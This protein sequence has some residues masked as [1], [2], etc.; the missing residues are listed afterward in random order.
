MHLACTA[1]YN[2]P[3]LTP[4]SNSSPFT[5]FLCGLVRRFGE[6]AD[7]A[8][9]TPIDLS[10]SVK[11]P[12]VAGAMSQYFPAAPP[13]GPFPNFNFDF[14]CQRQ[15]CIPGLGGQYFSDGREIKVTIL[16][17]QA[18]FTDEIR[19]LSP[20]NRVIGTNRDVGRVVSLGSFRQGTELIFGIYARDTGQTFKMGP[21]LRN[22][23]RIAHARVECLGGGNAKIFFEDY[24]G[25][26]DRDFDDAVFQITSGP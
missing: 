17:F 2:G 4:L 26:G 1:G 23:D 18:D 20:V 25:G 14:P 8:S 21:A 5:S 7:R 3:V 22:P 16:P 10:V 19:L 12:G 24:L 6:A 9:A 11:I 15:Q 13:F